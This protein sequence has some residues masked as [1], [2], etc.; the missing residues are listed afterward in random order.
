MT[1]GHRQR[2]VGG[3]GVQPCAGHFNLGLATFGHSV[4]LHSLSA[5]AGGLSQGEAPS[6]EVERDVGGGENVGLQRAPKILAAPFQAGVGPLA[7]FP[8]ATRAGDLARVGDLSQWATGARDL[9]RG[10]QIEGSGLCR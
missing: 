9:E 6:G 5:R 4:G 8:D 7:R 3:R 10:G 1:G 2:A